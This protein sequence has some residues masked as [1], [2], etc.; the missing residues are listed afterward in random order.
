M[1]SSDDWSQLSDTWSMVIGDDKV[2]PLN[3]E[4]C[5]YFVLNDNPDTYDDEAD[6][7]LVC[8]FPYDTENP[9]RPPVAGDDVVSLEKG[10]YQWVLMSVLL[11]N[12]VDPDGDK[13][14]MSDVSDRTPNL[15]L[16]PTG[17][18]IYVHHDGSD[19]PSTGSFTY[20]VSDGKG[21]T[22]KATVTVEIT[23]QNRA[24]TAKDDR[25]SIAQGE[26]EIIDVRAN[27]NDLD[28]DDL[29]VSIATNPSHGTTTVIASGSDANR[30]RYVHNGGAA[31]SDSFTYTVSD[32]KGGTDSATVTITV[33][34]SG[35]ALTAVQ[36]A[37][38]TITEGGSSTLSWTPG[39][40]VTNVFISGGG[41]SGVRTSGNSHEVTPPRV[42][43]VTYT[44][45]AEDSDG[46]PL[47]DFTV[48]I[49][50]ETPPPPLPN[51]ELSVPPES[52][53]K[54]TP[55]FN[56]GRIDGLRINEGAS[57]SFSVRLESEPIGEVT[58]TGSIDKPDVVTISRSRLTFTES[59]WDVEQFVNVEVA[60]D[61][62]ARDETVV[63]TY[64]VSGSSAYGEP[65]EGSVT[66]KVTD[67]DT[68]PHPPEEEKQAV[69]ETVRAVAAATAANVAANIGT[70]FSTARGGSSLVVGGQKVSLG[71][72]PI[73][74]P[75]AGHDSPIGADR[76][77]ETRHLGFDE[78]LRS[79]AFEMTLG[80][81]EDGSPGVTDS[82]HLTFWGRG[83]L[84]FFESRPARG[85]RYDGDLM[86]GYLGVEAWIGERWLAGVAA[87]RTLAEASYGVAGG[88]DGDGRLEMS[89]TNVHPYVRYA[90]DARSE[91]WAFLG[92]GRGEIEIDPMDEDAARDKSGVRMWMGSVGG[93]RALAPSG[94]LDLAL[95]GD[96]G[97]ARVETDKDLEVANIGRLT[98]DTWRARFGVEGSHTIELERGVLTPF[99]EVAGRWDGSSDGND[100]A[101]V[102]LAGGLYLADPASGLGIEARGRALALHTA[103]DYDEFGG[104]VTASLSP[105]ADGTGLSLSLTPRWGAETEGANA[106]W[107]EAGLERLERDSTDA[108]ALSLDARAGYGIDAAGGLLTPFGELGLL[109]RDSRRVRLGVRFEGEDPALQKRLSLELSGERYDG[110][111]DASPEHRVGLI[112]RLR[113]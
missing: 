47:G 36:P 91:V 44:L 79:S 71:P 107:R 14:T 4:Y 15:R 68:F 108:D 58:L 100:E 61:S 70:R 34:P 10:T 96:L 22:D 66:I 55:I 49:T 52:M 99:L 87:S 111:G 92:V 97:F 48:T 45:S 33:N 102:E 31:T 53:S 38:A 27:D 103:E 82:P 21:G 46:G 24:P 6:I 3:S 56:D 18:A 85:P 42:G 23:G 112:G 43:A 57:G 93:R 51:V 11:Q 17:G 98:T 25:I 94:A 26:T 40:D 39:P 2:Y 7:G 50:V 59:D 101:G 1:T 19:E 65:E 77:V 69:T 35:P 81:A 88:G 86:A 41:L 54:V 63:F 13:I 37:P 90:L 28:G 89:L 73:N 106:L 60:K 12:D 83:D 75:V 72:L 29:T 5:R 20:T 80:A 64:T 109:E 113:F 8:Q 67:V 30:I 84:E 105:R 62:D 110:R 76:A 78:L 95:L 32:G 74:A 104:S 9:N 16:D